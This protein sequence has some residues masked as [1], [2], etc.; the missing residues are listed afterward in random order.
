M[1]KEILIK[2]K[3]TAEIALD[4]L[5]D[6]QGNLKKLKDD[7][8]QKLKS[9]IIKYGFRFPVFVWKSNINNS[10]TLKYNYVYSY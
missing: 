7:E 1:E 6:F 2:C 5:Q 3:G 9:S 8:Y 10:L 4:K